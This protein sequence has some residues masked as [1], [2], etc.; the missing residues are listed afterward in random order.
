MVRQQR[1][2]KK[3]N[4][5][6]SAGHLSDAWLVFYWMKKSYD[7]MGS[8][9]LLGT[10]RSGGAE[11]SGRQKILGQGASR[12]DSYCGKMALEPRICAGKAR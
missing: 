7:K 3:S 2:K 12:E 1:S 9:V 8:L 11:N 6:K 10:K 5:Q 4:S